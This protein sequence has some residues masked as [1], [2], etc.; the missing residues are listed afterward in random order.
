MVPLCCRLA[1]V[2]LYLL[3]VSVAR[4]A[5][6]PPADLHGRL[7]AQDGISIVEIWGT[8]EKAGF[9][10]GWLV[11]TDVVELFDE[12]VLHPR[13]TPSPA[14]YESSILPA[15]CGRFEWPEA[16]RA[17]IEG[18]FAGAVAR[19]G[20]SKVYSKRLE[21]ALR[22]ED[23]LVANSMADWFGLMCSS[24]SAWGS[25]S[26]GG[27]TI[28]A[29]NLDFPFTPTMRKAQ[30]VLV[31][32][33]DDSKHAWATVTWPGLIG[34]Y[35]GMNDAGVTMLMHDS[36]GLPMSAGLPFTPRSL[37][38]REALEAASAATFIDDV[39]GVFEK[40]RVMVGNNIHVSR[41]ADESRPA[42]D[43]PNAAIFEYD[44]NKQGHGVTLRLGDAKDAA[45]TNGAP[46]ASLAICTNHMRSRRD[47]QRCER[48]E[49]LSAELAKLAK[50]GRRLDGRGA[51][52]LLR[53]VTRDDTLHSI[54]LLPATQTILL[55]LPKVRDEPVEIRLAPLFQSPN[56]ESTRR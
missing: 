22:V 4:A 44:A 41:P 29:R 45:S 6:T 38:L 8:P 7:T 35:T 25:L 49:R 16:Y 52:D 37:V 46:P 27:Q 18:V 31:R 26:E 36:N 40:R 34:V 15:A 11:A 5:D 9:A 48:Y 17:E 19:L 10:Y 23:L 56:P 33:A 1:L 24:F 53:C 54:A 47:P 39:R 28:T 43:G 42:A 14:L 50:D 21:R 55:R 51:L 30:L 12:F 2:A 32:R 20:A 3:S 13:I